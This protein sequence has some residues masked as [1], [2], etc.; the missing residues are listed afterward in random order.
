MGAPLGNTNAKSAKRWADALNRAL[1][2]AAEGKGFE[3]GLD[4]VADTVVAHAIAGSKEAWQEI[5]NRQDGKPAQSLEI[6][7][8]VNGSLTLTIASTDPE[9]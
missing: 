6:D 1:A 2:R 9:L 5:G 8:N 3:A 4:K 7:A